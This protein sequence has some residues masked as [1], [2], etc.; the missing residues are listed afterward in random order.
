[1]TREGRLV[2]VS[3]SQRSKLICNEGLPAVKIKGVWESDVGAIKVWRLG[4]IEWSNNGGRASVKDVKR[5][6]EAKKSGPPF[7]V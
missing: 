1:M 3:N 7:N 6:T 4:K 5:T 2:K